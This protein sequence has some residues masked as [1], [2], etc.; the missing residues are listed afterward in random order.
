MP[1]FRGLIDPWVHQKYDWV[2]WAK[3][4]NVTRAYTHVLNKFSR[5]KNVS[6]HRKKSTE[7]NFGEEYFDWVYIDADHS[8]E[9]V[10]ADLKHWYPQV[11]KGGFL[12]GDDYGWSHKLTAG[13]KPAVVEFVKSH[14]LEIEI[15]KNQYVI[16]KK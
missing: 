6:I 10:K 7:I 12:C 13:P 8:Y 14:N 1:P 15:V 2:K 11:K 5:I 4:Q 9:S 16:Q 3:G